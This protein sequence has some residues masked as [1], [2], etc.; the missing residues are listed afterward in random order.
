MLALDHNWYAVGAMV[1][2]KIPP[3]LLVHFLLFILGPFFT[4]PPHLPLRRINGEHGGMIAKATGKVR[5][6]VM[7]M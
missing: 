2:L 1:Y 4:L 6:N 5:T 3:H 7:D